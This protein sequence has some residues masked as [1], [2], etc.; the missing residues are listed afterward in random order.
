MI[1]K[2]EKC[3]TAF[4]I[5][6]QLI[7]DSGTKFR[8]SSCHHVFTVYPPSALPEPEMPRAEIKTE[9][10]EK[11]PEES[12]P[13]LSE[14]DTMTMV[15][16]SEEVFEKR[17]EAQTRYIEVGNIGEGGMGEVKLAKDTQLLRK[18]ALKSLKKDAASAATLSYFFREA[19]IT[20][21]LDHPNIVPLYTVKEPAPNEPAVSF[22]MKYIK[23][24]TLTDIITKARNI[25]KENPKAQLPEELNLN[26]RLGYFLKACEG[27]IYA[28]RKEV[29]HRDLKPSNIMVGD[30]GEVY[31]MDWGIAKMI[32]EIPE[33][34]YGIQKVAAKKTDMY[35]GG[36]EVGSVVG[37][38][39]YIS[40]EQVKGQPDVGA[41]S[42]QFSLG[43]IL[44]ELVTLKPA[45]P[46]DMAKK[47][48]WA[49]E[50]TLNRMVHLLPEKKIAPELKAII[51]KAT[52]PDPNRR[53]LSTGILAEDVRRFL[54]GDEV[55]VMPDNLP[56]RM[57][58]LIN[59]HRH[60]TAILV[61]SFLLISSAV[62]TFTLIREKSAMKKAR[63]REKKL[64]HLLTKVATQA[65]YI[66]SRFIRLEGLL[67]NL[68]N[69]AMYM[70]QYSQEGGERFYWISDFK[71]PD[72]A[73]RDYTESSL[74]RRKVS[75]DYPVVKAAPGVNRE[76]VVPMMQRLAPL[77]HHFK[78]VLLD[79]RNNYSP[80]TDEEARRLLTIHGLP[81]SW[82]Y[83]GLEAGVMYSYPGKATYGDD[84]D[85]RKRP[86]YSLGARKRA[87][88]W[89][90]PYIDINGLGMVL[91]C[92]TS[93][94][95]KEGNFYGVAGMDVTYS[96]I[97]QDSLTRSGSVGVVESFLLDDQARIVVSSSQ[98]GLAME[99]IPT[100]SALQLVQFPVAEVVAK[101]RRKESGFVEVI[102]DNELR[103]IFFHEIPSLHWYYLEDVKKAAILGTTEE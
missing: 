36:T 97:I 101:I 53:Y 55:T 102:R 69:N 9:I 19:Q 78:K 54:R 57:W 39:G 77:R 89:G 43:V 17:D 21:Q 99:T 83:L 28:H 70:I 50:G 76:D 68:A 26:S 38:P 66:D 33:T 46:G 88:Y 51:K 40:P 20:A 34:L 56:R 73:P 5:K 15:D 23:G 100:D 45:R 30:Y 37:T 95:D 85:P 96:N 65:H 63:I 87:V 61:L 62:T 60:I 74:Y 24:Q 49:N 72:K 14:N 32:K 1:A 90:N 67:V 16:F 35:L 84:Y 75:I 81:I 4:N 48:E 12:R 64:T 11:L 103:I 59:K 94:Y 91:P 52:E 27:V 13:R 31:V 47:L 79:S 92:A 80:I 3:R 58:R 86:W 18:V 41:A 82:A 6:D 25:Y 10:R 98:L 22:V 93:L 8:C 2:C 42:D 44:Y 29:I 71:D 7:K